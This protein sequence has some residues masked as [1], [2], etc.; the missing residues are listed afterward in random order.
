MRYHLLAIATICVWG[1]TFVST[2]VL[3]NHGLTPAAIFFLR[4]LLAYAGLVAIMR[5]KHWRCTSWRDEM[6]AALAGVTGGSAY[7]LTENTALQYAQAGNVSFI[8]CLAP[9]ITAIL[10]AAGRKEEKIPA[11]LWAG[12]VVALVGVAFIIQ[13][14][15]SSI[16]GH[17]LLGNGLALS[18]ATLWAFYQIIT[19]P[20]AA[21]YGTA[22]LS[23]KVFGYGLLSIAGFVAW[24]LPQS[25]MPALAAPVVWG[26]LLFLGMVA[27][28]VCYLTWNKVV[29]KLGSV[30]S[31]NY[32]YL[33]PL[34][35]CLFSYI[36]LDEAFTFTM[37]CGGA[38]ILAGIY[39]AVKPASH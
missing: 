21:R 18:A 20:L 22:M 19:Q 28:L 10:A 13:G 33:N 9:L 31:A 25:D 14:N 12:S 5:P 37:L 16:L 39:W 2:K 38:A 35:T 30:V 36:F 1:T 8:V 29:E 27:S 7:F 15:D 4:F 24:E 11:R 6:L 34:V 3:L 32:I 17:N 26:N 23:R